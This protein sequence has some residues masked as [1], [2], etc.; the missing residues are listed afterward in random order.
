MDET[1]LI[2]LLGTAFGGMAAWAAIKADIAVTR[3]SANMA[4]KRAE[5]AHDRINE[6]IEQ[7]HTFS[8]N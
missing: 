3:H 2:Q 6:H 4:A 8:K 5:S 7:H 1:F